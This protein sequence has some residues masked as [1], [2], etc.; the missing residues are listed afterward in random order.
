TLNSVPNYMGSYGDYNTSLAVDPAD[1]NVVYAGG[2]VDMIRT[3]NGGVSWT[4]I[5][6][7]HVHPDFHAAGFDA[8][9][10]YLTGGDGGIWRLNNPVGLQWQD[11]NGSLST[12]QLA[13]IALNPND[14]NIAYAGAQDNY[15]EKFTGSLAWTALRGGDGGFTRVDWAHPQTVYM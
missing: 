5:L 15:S 8:N 2:Q 4:H 3:A 7:S 12:I 1:P 13:G 10:K 14:P 6:D 11:L 9:G